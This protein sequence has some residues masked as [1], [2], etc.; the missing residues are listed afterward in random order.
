MSIK[1]RHK[2]LL[3]NTNHGG[4]PHIIDGITSMML[5]YPYHLAGEQYM[6]VEVSAQGA[7]RYWFEVPNDGHLESVQ[8]SQ[9]GAPLAW[10]WAG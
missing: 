5:A 2:L 3:F 8:F 9:M 7:F 6:A 10:P 4:A 1:A